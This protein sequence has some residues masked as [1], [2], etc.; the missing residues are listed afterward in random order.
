MITLTHNKHKPISEKI[1]FHSSPSLTLL[2]QLPPSAQGPLHTTTSLAVTLDRFSRM[3]LCPEGWGEVVLLLL[4]LLFLRLL[5]HCFLP[6][7]PGWSLISLRKV[8][9]ASS[10]LTSSLDRGEGCQRS[11]E[12]GRSI[13]SIHYVACFKVPLRQAFSQVYFTVHTHTHTHTHTQ[14]LSC[15]FLVVCIFLFH[16]KYNLLLLIII[17]NK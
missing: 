17:I 9:L 11:R 3:Q 5:I 15:C 1:Y 10:C 13:I 12:G 8:A 6:L 4:L 14:E 16:C 2:L 7:S